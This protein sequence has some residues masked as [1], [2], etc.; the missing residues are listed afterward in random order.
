M[1]TPPDF[2]GLE[3]EE[4]VEEDLGAP[5]QHRAVPHDDSAVST[6]NEAH[7]PG[8]VCPRCGTVITP[9]Q[10]VRRRAD[11]NWIHEI[12]PAVAPGTITSGGQ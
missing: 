10:D 7:A 4:G 5:P 6:D 8:N 2:G 12:C 9:G 1:T 11:G 3:I